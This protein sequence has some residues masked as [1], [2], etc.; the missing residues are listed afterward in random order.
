MKQ[1]RD[2]Q[3]VAGSG[4]FLQLSCKT[5][6]EQDTVFWRPLQ[7]ITRQFWTIWTYQST[8]V[9]FF[10]LFF[11]FFLLNQL[12]WWSLF[13]LLFFLNNYFSD[14]PDHTKCRRRAYSRIIIFFFLLN[15]PFSDPLDH[16]KC[17]RRAYLRIVNFFF[18]CKK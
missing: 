1:L 18:R 13:C 10:H 7:S 9:L 3:I 6:F 11:H 17:K 5:L 12:K 14:P 16:T 8:W 4:Q 2:C 15:N